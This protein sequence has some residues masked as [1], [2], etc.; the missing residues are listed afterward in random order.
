M[1]LGL[2]PGFTRQSSLLDFP[3]EAPAL[4]R[5]NGKLPQFPCFASVFSLHKLLRSRPCTTSA[6][7]ALVPVNPFLLRLFK[8]HRASVYLCT[9]LI[10]SVKKEPMPTFSHG[11]GLCFWSI[12][13]PTYNLEGRRPCAASSMQPSGTGTSPR[14]TWCRLLITDGR[15]LSFSPRPPPGHFPAV[16]LHPI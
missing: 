16:R 15:S 2:F 7:S 9:K 8:V 1:A 5:A 6:P 10:T 4:S 11:R 12:L 3:R 13:A 14:S